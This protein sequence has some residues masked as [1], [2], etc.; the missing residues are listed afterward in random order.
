[1]GIPGPEQLKKMTD[2]EVMHVIRTQGR[3]GWGLAQQALDELHYRFITK[4]Q[5]STTNLVTT[6]ENLGLL[7]SNMTEATRDVHR[8]VTIL[9]QSSRHLERLTARLKGLT[10]VLIILTF[11]AVIV[12]VGLEIWKVYRE[13][14]NARFMIETRPAQAPQR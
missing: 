4:I 2:E 13:A 9:T 7:I 3:P 11:V 12:P 10:W 14:E 1:M 8:E 6:S 5:T